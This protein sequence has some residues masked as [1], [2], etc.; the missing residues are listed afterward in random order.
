MDV[1]DL[2]AKLSLD[3]SGYIAATQ[4]AIEY[5][6]RIVISL[7]SAADAA[8]NLQT[9]FSGTGNAINQS[10]SNYQML[11]SSLESVSAEYQKAQNRVESISA[12]YDRV[13]KATG[14]ESDETRNLAAKLQAAQSDASRL[15][16]EMNSLRSKMDSASNATADEA[17]ET[18]NARSEMGR[19]GNTVQ[20]AGNKTRDA[21]SE[22]GKFV[23]ALSGIASKAASAVDGIVKIGSVAIGA[24]STALTKLTKDSLDAYSEYEQL[25]GGTELMFGDAYDYVIEKSQ[26]AYQTVQMSQNEYLQQVNGFATGLKTAL[27]GNERAAAELADRIITAEADIVAATGN[28]QESV[29]NAF[30]G[31]MRS[32]YNML[33]NLSLGI[34]P[35]KE[36]FQEIIDKVNEW[37]A[38]NGK[39]TSYVIDNLADAQNA[40]VDYIEMQGYAGYASMEASGTISGSLSSIKAAWKNFMTGTGTVDQ[41]ASVLTSFVSNTRES[42]QKIIPNLTEGLTQ[43]VDILSPEIPPLIEQMLPT[44]ITGASMLISGLAKRLPQLITAILPSL[45][46]GVVDVTTALVTVLPELVSSLSQSVPI[47]V[48]TIMSKKDELVQ[49]GK[50]LISSIFPQDLSGITEIASSASGVITNFLGKLTDTENIGKILNKGSDIIDALIDGLLSQESLGAIFDEENGVGQVISNLVD[51]FVHFVEKVSEAAT[52]III[53]LDEFLQNEENK[54]KI[55]ETAKQILT[56]LGNGFKTSVESVAPLI[57]ETCKLLADTFIGG[58]DWN[59][60]GGEIAKQI[61][62]GV[63]NNLWTTK[64]GSLI[65]ESVADWTTG[66]EQDYLDDDTAK[67][68]DRYREDRLN[69]GNS[70]A[71]TNWSTTEKMIDSGGM[72]TAA[73]SA[74]QKARGY[75]K[76]GLFKKPSIIEVGEDGDEAVIPLKNNTEWID[77]VA[78]RLNRFFSR[79]SA[80][81][82]KLP[83]TMYLNFNSNENR[84]T[85]SIEDIKKMISDFSSGITEAVQRPYVEHRIIEE[86]VTNPKSYELYGRTDGETINLSQEIHIHV[87]GDEQGN[88]GDAIVD[89]IDV[90]LRNRQIRLNRGV[91]SIDI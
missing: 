57:V 60:T 11:Q 55:K 20:D 24:V 63:Y 34:N 91:G 15:S 46:S 49:A 66:I 56:T 43:L 9:M 7:A 16:D 1:F 3:V 52:K 48:R 33:D 41:F 69:E 19:Y 62:K 54:E 22:T 39:A 75:A 47:V 87:S 83:D 14:A 26:N 59:A 32:N 5:G 36:G 64:L 68:Y 53:K 70:Q 12:A 84:S 81:I 44:I 30:N 67:T 45:A 29:Q 23:E 37:N 77:E 74:Y 27:G 90:A 40:L 42:L 10:S 79:P 38:T 17:S 6:K 35:S 58:I 65:G 50:D 89:Q 88:I 78:A 71:P 25:S 4:N 2:Y 72:S 13:S 86:T 80:D 76:G 18:E 31:I 8:K 28:T 73:M 51:G 85:A 82:S 21:T 61:V